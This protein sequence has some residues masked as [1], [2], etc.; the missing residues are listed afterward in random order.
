MTRRLTRGNPLGDL[1]RVRR[2]ELG[3]SKR[4]AAR[5][6]GI[7]ASYLLAL[8][9][10]RNPTTGRPPEPSPSVLFA[11]ADALSLDSHLLL[12]VAGGFPPASIHAAIYDTRTRPASAIPAARAIFSDTVEQWV[13]VTDSG[14]DPPTDVTVLRIAGPIG[15]SNDGRSFSPTTALETLLQEF[16]GQVPSGR[17]LGIVFGQASAALRLTADLAVLDSEDT[18]EQDVATAVQEATDQPP[19]AIVCVYRRADL[20][21]AAPIVDPLGAIVQLL[22][23]H[24][25]LA[26]VTGKQILTG[27][28]AAEQMLLDARPQGAEEHSWSLLA[29]AA[30]AGISNVATS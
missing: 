28:A 7:S 1:V 26:A 2:E 10:G 6:M 25:L 24:P 27:I 17:R 9:A 16:A 18:W 29:R 23:T 30:A 14:H 8:E 4:E 15:L 11:L 12:R 5:R 19:S 22:R 13:E 21:A 3:M 20:Q